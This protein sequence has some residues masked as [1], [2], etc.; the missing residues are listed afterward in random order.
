MTAKQK[1]TINRLMP[2]I[3]AI[4]EKLKNNPT[5][6]EKFRNALEKIIKKVDLLR[7]KL[8]KQKNTK[9]ELLEVLSQKL[10]EIL[11]FL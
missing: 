5:K 1:A 2:K 6:L 7:E 3:K 9:K 8:L 4:G 10:K 11:S